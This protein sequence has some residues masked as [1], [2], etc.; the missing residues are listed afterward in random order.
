MAIAG[1]VTNRYVWKYPFRTLL[2]R[3]IERTYFQP[4]PSR[5]TVPLG[6]NSAAMNVLHETYQMQ[7][8]AMHDVQNVY[9]F[10]PAVK[11]H[12]Q[13]KVRQES[14]DEREEQQ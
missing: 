7:M 2:W 1:W 9:F 6:R 10:L 11:K 14:E 3:P 4:D 5:W 13:A 8:Y 12:T